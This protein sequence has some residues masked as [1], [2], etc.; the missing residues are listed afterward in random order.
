MGIIKVSGIRLHGFHGCLPEEAKIGGEFRVDVIIDAD[1]SAAE[2]SDQ[3]ADTIDYCVI[4]DIV[5]AEMAI[6]SKLIEEVCRRILDK[7]I[8]RFPHCG[9]EVNITKLRPPMNGDVESVSVVLS[10]PRK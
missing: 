8:A 9:F 6:R 5:K 4:Y 3:L 10:V 2:K 1:F 7:F